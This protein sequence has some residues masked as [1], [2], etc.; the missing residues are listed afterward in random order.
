MMQIT[1]IGLGL[2]MTAVAV[3]FAGLL[4]EATLL[5]MGRALRDP[6]VA[7]VRLPHPFALRWKEITRRLT[8]S[9]PK[10][11]RASRSTIPALESLGPWAITPD[12]HE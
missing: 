4:L 11:A 6:L 8:S 5:M 12:L 10:R 3:A 9:L 1:A 7:Q 2:M